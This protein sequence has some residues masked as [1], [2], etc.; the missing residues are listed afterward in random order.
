MAQ[1]AGAERRREQ[2]EACDPP[3]ATAI[4]PRC[5]R[6]RFRPPLP[7]DGSG[8]NSATASY[9]ALLAPAEAGEIPRLLRTSLHSELELGGEVWRKLDEYD[10]LGIR[11]LR[12]IGHGSNALS[13]YYIPGERADLVS[14]SCLRKLPASQQKAVRAYERRFPPGPGYCL[15]GISDREAFPVACGT[16]GQPSAGYVFGLSRTSSE[17]LVGLVADGVATVRVFYRGGVATSGAVSNNLFFASA[18]RPATRDLPC[19][20]AAAGRKQ[21]CTKRERLTQVRAATPL[22]VRWLSPTGASVRQFAL[23]PAYLRDA[24]EQMG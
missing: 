17:R 13:Y 22:A 14:S 4:A 6:E 5:P 3:S 10:P 18:P 16:L 2:A 11:R 15:V 7:V 21:P 23:T 20:I 24:E 12:Q 8:A 9:A 1:G 19:E